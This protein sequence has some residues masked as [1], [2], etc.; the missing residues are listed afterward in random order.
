MCDREPLLKHHLCANWHN[1]HHFEGGTGL[2]AVSL[3]MDI[4]EQIFMLLKLPLNTDLVDLRSRLDAT[5]PR[6][7]HF[8]G[9]EVG[10][11]ETLGKRGAFR[12]KAATGQGGLYLHLTVSS[13]R[14]IVNLLLSWKGETGGG[15]SR[16][17]RVGMR[18]RR[19]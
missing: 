19:R 12:E 9:G 16:F 13:Q 5:P 17:H 11:R 8:V 4:I 14:L 15:L 10:T 3:P 6:G 2:I 7:K 18:R 1:W